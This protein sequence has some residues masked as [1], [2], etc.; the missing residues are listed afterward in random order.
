MGMLKI[1]RR[2]LVGI[3]G[4]PSVNLT[5]ASIGSALYRRT[6][7]EIAASVIPTNYAYGTA[8]YDVRRYGVVGDGVT[9]DASALSTAFSV[10]G[11]FIIPAGMNCFLGTS[12][13]TVGV[14]NTRITMARNAKFSVNTSRVSSMPA[15]YLLVTASGVT[16]NGLVLDFG[17]SP[18][19]SGV[20][21]YGP[22]G[23]FIGIHGSGLSDVT[24]ENC[25]ANYT[26]HAVRS[27]YTD[28]KTAGSI[29]NLT[30]R[31]NKFRTVDTGIYWTA[32]SPV[33]IKIYGNVFDNPNNVYLRNGGAVFI[34]PSVA[35]ENAAAF[36]EAMYTRAFGKG[37]EIFGNRINQV[38]GRPIRV[39][40][41]VD[42]TVTGN[43]VILNKGTYTPNA[44]NNLFSADA[45]TF[46]MVRGFSVTNNTLE[47]GGENGMD[48]LSCQDGTVT[49][50]T[51]KQVNTAG[52]FVGFSDVYNSGGTAFTIKQRVLSRNITITGNA[53][54]AWLPF[55]HVC[56]Q[57]ICFNGNQ[58][59]LYRTSTNWAAGNPE[60]TL[61]NWDNSSLPSAILYGT[62]TAIDKS[63]V[64]D[65]LDFS[66]NHQVKYAQKVC[67]FGASNVITT[68][69]AAGRAIA[70]EYVTGDRIEFNA[71][72]AAASFSFPTGV[73]FSTDYYVIALSATTFSIA[74]SWANAFARNAVSTGIFANGNPASGGVVYVYEALGRTAL[75]F[76]ATYYNA[77][78]DIQFDAKAPYNA[79]VTA[80][81][82]L[83][84][85]STGVPFN[86]KNVI[87]E[88]IL[89]PATAYHSSNNKETYGKYWPVAPIKLSDGSA[90]WGIEVTS[91]G[92]ATVTVIT[93]TKPS[94]LSGSSSADLIRT[95][96]Y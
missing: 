58:L 23:G 36:T 39:H 56:G 25:T 71:G 35:P 11:D 32:V 96:F 41:S 79:V 16:L 6:R 77:N 66:G 24:I 90:T 67:T 72:G 31:N 89:N 45:F 94:T 27:V 17:S 26:L 69:N 12:A 82:S 93:G 10:G 40:N 34:A 13:V 88:V 50:N 43:T 73:A 52:I 38:V 78:A 9:N 54:E 48:F 91:V 81:G 76:S 29:A 21:S 7:A 95:R 68:V 83:R 80:F 63:L 5:A 8:P 33:G 65:R 20:H 30:I 18:Y 44:A 19:A 84:K 4:L 86:F 47:G 64:P 15:D 2:Q 60:P 62:G 59:K 37:I 14:A 49:G 61:M 22:N 28:S 55:T 70:H 75:N 87:N 74:T 3:A 1:T 42:V 53:I 57:D 46:D 85:L 92:P 51:V